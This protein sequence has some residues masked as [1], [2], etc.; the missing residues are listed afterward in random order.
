MWELPPRL[1]A[2]RVAI[3]SVDGPFP[4]KHRDASSR[5]QKMAART[6]AEAPDVNA[7][8]HGADT[9]AHAGWPQARENVS[10][11]SS[12]FYPG[13]CTAHRWFWESHRPRVSL[14]AGRGYRWAPVCSLLLTAPHLAFCLLPEHRTS[15]GEWDRERGARASQQATLPW[16]QS[17]E[18]RCHPFPA[19]EE[20]VLRNSCWPTLL[21]SD[22]TP[23][24][25]TTTPVPGC[26][27][28]GWPLLA[29]RGRPISGRWAN[30]RALESC[31]TLLT[32]AM[33]SHQD[34][35]VAGWSLGWHTGSLNHLGAWSP[36]RAARDPTA[37]CP[38]C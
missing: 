25:P 7:Q 4:D 1:L 27:E 9:Q 21:S 24:P 28:P 23:P 13:E 15:A 6:G 19:S 3:G 34:L 32:V 10:G 30:T 22:I 8:P 17:G 37:W 5:L 35:S 18:Q 29:S 14:W 26:P 20:R 12:A 31:T 33:T 16:T 11:I 38:T 2:P 36:Y